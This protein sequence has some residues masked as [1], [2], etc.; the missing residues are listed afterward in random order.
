MI[1][2]YDRIR[3]IQPPTTRVSGRRVHC[4]YN[5]IKTTYVIFFRI[6][7]ELFL[8]KKNLIATAS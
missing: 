2:H 3:K 4:V 5:K 8:F 7:V 1:V 6:S